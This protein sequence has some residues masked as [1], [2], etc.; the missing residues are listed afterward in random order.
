MLPRPES[1]SRTIHLRRPAILSVVD[2]PH[3]PDVPPDMLAEVEWRWEALCRANPRYFDGRLYHVFGVH[4]NGHGGAVIHVA[5]CAYRYHAVQ[6]EDLDLGVRPLGTKGLIQCADRF[7]L[8]KRAMTVGS[9]QSAWEFRFE[10][11]DIFG[12]F[13]GF[14]SINFK[15]MLF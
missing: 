4:R 13:S 15:F 2:E 14:K 7:L 10:V 3:V 9:Y 8:G 12:I 5:D 1:S 6:N 11:I